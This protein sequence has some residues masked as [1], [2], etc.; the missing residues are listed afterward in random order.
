[1]N[2][3]QLLF[4]SAIFKKKNLTKSKAQFPPFLILVGQEKEETLL[5]ECREHND[6]NQLMLRVFF[7]PHEDVGL[8]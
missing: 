7:F 3:R 4:T 1:M 5:R 6:N 8:L 2:T